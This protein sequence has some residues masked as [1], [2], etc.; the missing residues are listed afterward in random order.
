MKR[1]QPNM[2]RTLAEATASEGDDSMNGSAITEPAMKSITQ[3]EEPNCEQG[4]F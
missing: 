3:T 4:R 1:I 2:R